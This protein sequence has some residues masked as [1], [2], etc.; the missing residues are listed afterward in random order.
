MIMEK[1]KKGK[2]KLALEVCFNFIMVHKRFMVQI[3]S[4]KQQL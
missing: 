3:H 1:K 4:I 2:T